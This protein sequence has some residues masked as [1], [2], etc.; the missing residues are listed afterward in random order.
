MED[1]SKSKIFWKSYGTALLIFLTIFLLSSRSNIYSSD[2]EDEI[3]GTYFDFAQGFKVASVITILYAFYRVGK[4]MEIK[5]ELES[6]RRKTF[7]KS[8][9]EKEDFR[10]LIGKL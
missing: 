3:I 1:Q 4:N 6:Y 2:N 7:F 10:E 9:E 8:K 5:D